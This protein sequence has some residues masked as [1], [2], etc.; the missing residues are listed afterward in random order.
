V[1]NSRRVWGYW[2][3][4]RGA[5]IGERPKAAPVDGI[6][7]YLWI[8]PPGE[9]DGTSDPKSSRYDSFCGNE[10]AATP[11]PDAGEWFETQFGALVSRAAPGL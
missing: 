1:V 4:V 11:A 2:C 5:G 3:N 7:A 9:S 6:D 8:K 10:D